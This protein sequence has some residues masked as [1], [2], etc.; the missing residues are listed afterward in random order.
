MS[1]NLFTEEE[2]SMSINSY[3]ISAGLFIR[4]LTNLKMQLTKAQKQAVD[5]GKDE[6]IFRYISCLFNGEK[7]SSIKQLLEDSDLGINIG[8]NNLVDKSLIHVKE[9]TVEMHH[10][11]Q[12]M[13]KLIVRT[14]SVEPGEREILMDSKDICHVLNNNTVSFFFFL[15]FLYK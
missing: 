6:A 15:F 2:Y 1:I 12:E 14:Q 8:F 4:G 7:V 13:G 10:L 5:S 11:L 3:D 9:D